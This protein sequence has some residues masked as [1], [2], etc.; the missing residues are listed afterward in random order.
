MG[1]I[2]RW[3]HATPPSTNKRS[4]LAAPNFVRDDLGFNGIQSQADGKR[5]DSRSGYYKSLKE[6]GAHIVEH[7]EPKPFKPKVIKGSGHDIKRAIQQLGG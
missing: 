4:K 6:Q 1:E 3:S 7:K 2:Y 5:Y